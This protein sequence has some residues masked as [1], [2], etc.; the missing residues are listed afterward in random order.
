MDSESNTDGQTPEMGSSGAM[1]EKLVILFTAFP[2]FL[3]FYVGGLNFGIFG[4]V[5]GAIIGVLA[6]HYVRKAIL[7]KM[8][9]PLSQINA[10]NEMWAKARETA[11]EDKV[12]Y[13]EMAA[14]ATEKSTKAVKKTGELTSGAIG[15]IKDAGVAAA[16]KLE[17]RAKHGNDSSPEA[18]STVEDD[19]A[20]RLENLS[21]LHEQGH[22]SDEEF[23]QQ[24]SR[25]LDE[26]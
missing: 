5:I 7:K 22:I 6:F 16:K 25:I 19:I 9:V 12:D 20:E 4:H 3:F 1:R 15:F 14:K 24:R 17:Q 2:C 21:N 26:V 18:N 8:R 10:R 11:T 23:A 13:A